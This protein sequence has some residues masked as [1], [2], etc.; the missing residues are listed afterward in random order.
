MSGADLSLGAFSVF[1]L[2]RSTLQ[3]REDCLLEGRIDQGLHVVD[4][5]R[6]VTRAEGVRPMATLQTDRRVALAQLG[7]TAEVGGHAGDARQ[8]VHQESAGR[9]QEVDYVP[10]RA[11]IEVDEGWR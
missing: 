11:E 6:L 7:Q 4:R 9:R 2:L 10:A 1:G 5:Q 8:L 3:V